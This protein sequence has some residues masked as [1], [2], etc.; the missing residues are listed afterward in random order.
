[1]E[2]IKEIDLDNDGFKDYVIG[3][4]GTNNKF[5]PSEEKPLHIYAGDLDGN[6]SFD[7]ALSKVS[8]TGELLPVRGKECSSQQ[9]PFI[10]NKLKT[11]E[12]FANS[13]LPGIYGEDRLSEATHFPNQQMRFNIF[14]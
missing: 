4:W 6:A 3:N 2:S 9:T 1:M 10:K 11:Y 7:M 5:H 12:E 14:S 8:K 13:T